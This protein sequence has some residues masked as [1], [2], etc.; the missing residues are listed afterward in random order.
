TAATAPAATTAAA[1][2]GPSPRRNSSWGASTSLTSRASRSPDR[3]AGSPHRGRARPAA[4]PGGPP[5]GGEPP[6]PPVH[7]HPQAGQDPERDVVGGD[8][9]GVTEDPAPHA[10]GAYRD[11]RPRDRQDRRVLR[12]A[13]QQET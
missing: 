11:H 8:P 9:F 5:G 1:S 2:G 12:R 4:R 6:Q 3:D 10:E 7:P 13:G